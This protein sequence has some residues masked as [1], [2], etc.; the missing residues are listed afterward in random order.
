LQGYDPKVTKV[1]QAWMKALFQKQKNPF[2][3]VMGAFLQA[4]IFISF[5]FA[6]HGREVT[7]IQ[8]RQSFV[9]H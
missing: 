6:K 4:P 3:P 5:F 1:N 7:F 9:V 2:T 8:G